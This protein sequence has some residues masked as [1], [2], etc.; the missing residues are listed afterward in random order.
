MDLGIENKLALVTGAS[1]G[2][3]RAIALRLAEEGASVILAARSGG[4]LESLK[5]ELSK[6]GKTH[7]A[8]EADFQNEAT[9]RD[10]I[11]AISSKVGAPDILVH[12]VGGSIAVTDPMASSEDWRRVWYFNLGSGLEINRAFVPAMQEK[13]WGR[14][15]HISSI[16]AENFSGYPAYVSSK[17]ALNAYV[18]SVGRNLAKKHVVLSAVAPGPMLAE[19]RYLAKLQASGGPEWEEYC[20][21]HLAIGR[22]G[23]PEEIAAATAWLCSD[24]ASFA[25]G[26]IFSIDG[27]AM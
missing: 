18:K 19:G 12:N 9:V 22:L 14:I 10:L 27:G 15:V 6:N 24:F 21:N 7:Y 11:A 2:M 17:A 3:G 5:E 4:L 25:V 16:S 8:F 23:R 13:K 26:S 1:K 20:R